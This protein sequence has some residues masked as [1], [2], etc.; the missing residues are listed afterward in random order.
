MQ[1]MFSQVLS[2]LLF[3]RLSSTLPDVTYDSQRNAVMFQDSSC[4]VVSET[5]VNIFIPPMSDAIDIPF[6]D[7]VS[8]DSLGALDVLA[9]RITFLVKNPMLLPLGL[10]LSISKLVLL[11]DSPRLGTVFLMSKCDALSVVM[12]DDNAKAHYAEFMDNVASIQPK[13]LDNRKHAQSTLAVYVPKT[14]QI[15][16]KD[17]KNKLALINYTQDDL[18]NSSELSLKLLRHSGIRVVKNAVSTALRQRQSDLITNQTEL[19]PILEKPAFALDGRDLDCLASKLSRYRNM[20][21]LITVRL[22]SA[23]GRLTGI[24]L[25]RISN[26]QGHFFFKIVKVDGIY[27]L[28]F[29]VDTEFLVPVSKR[30]KEVEE[31][32]SVT[33]QATDT[34]ESVLQHIAN[35]VCAYVKKQSGDT[36]PHFN[37]L[38][39]AQ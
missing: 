5:G 38:L 28:R 23:T 14:Q 7:V 36:Q 35:A 32:P 31:L 11:T 33:L 2:C 6:V 17:A 4:L 21:V 27:K 13:P 22:R 12:M 15:S 29:F 34:G 24:Y 37:P 25:P 18:K 10:R 26:V 1:S 39:R 30:T 19:F 20:S 3:T 8:Y 16:K 9:T